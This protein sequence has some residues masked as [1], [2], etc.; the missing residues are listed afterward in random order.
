MS[1]ARTGLVPAR[2][3][4]E[5]LAGL[6]RA[7]AA[8]RLPH[9]LLFDGPTGVGKFLAARY[10]AA[11]ILCA[12]G[13][14][15]P[16]GECG[17][18]HRMGSGGEE[19]NHPDLLEVDPISA[20]EESIRI[21]HIAFRE[22]DP[23]PEPVALR[24]TVEGFLDLKPHE[25][26][27]RVVIVREAERMNANAQNALLKTLEEPRLGTLLV[28]VTSSADRL[29]DTVVSRLT[30]VAFGHLDTETS[31]E[32]IGSLTPGLDS[33][34][35]RD[36]ARW[37]GGSP[38]RA[39]ELLAQGRAQQTELLEG[40]LTG[41]RGPISTG[42]DLWLAEGEFQGK[43]ERAKERSRARGVLDLALELCADLGA[44]EAGVP[45]EHLVHGA[46]VAD[47]LCP[48]SLVRLDY[49]RSQLVQAR[50]DVDANLTPSAVLDSA[51][52]ALAH[53]APKLP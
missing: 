22:N 1:S 7:A 38:G 37:S 6:W 35:T 26:G 16:C 11:G 51:L 20:G 53:L 39:M 50:A 17:P 31:A 8:D 49:V 25:A 33:Q 19:S 13:P 21:A 45:A 46:L 18:C 30:R 43:T 28:L 44:L 12:K 41:R 14:G 3:H 34:Q 27:A 40:V 2:G 10:F 4:E 36:L 47:C 5:V 9:A 32:L 15:T 29:L 42:R 52:L 24:R 48:G 23:G